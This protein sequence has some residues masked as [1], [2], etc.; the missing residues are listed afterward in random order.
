VKP[1][2]LE[3]GSILLDEVR[4]SDT[5]AIYEYC[6]D[7]VFEQFLTTPWPYTRAHAEGYV[8]QFVPSGW[9]KDKEYTWALRRHEGAP[10]MGVISL[11][12]GGDQSIG[13]WLGAENRG[14]G[15]MPTAVAAL[16]DW[17]FANGRSDVRWECIEGNVAS[18]AVARKTGFTFTG[19][20][21]AS[22]PMR[23][24]SY[25]ESWH[26]VL[27]STDSRDPKPGWPA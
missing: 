19:A 7:P 21:P 17:A 27:L 2:A 14:H 4:G 9:A 22:A 18:L 26:G 15:Y 20:G 5:L 1:F 24:G 13:F 6:Q 8:N 11:R 12:V 23:D 25:R 10:L 16:A 3:A